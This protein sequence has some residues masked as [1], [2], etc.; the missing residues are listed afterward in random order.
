MD[1]NKLTE[2]LREKIVAGDKAG[3]NHTAIQLIQLYIDR[4]NQSISP[5]ANY[6]TV[7]AYFAL[8]KHTEVLEKLLDD[9]DKELLMQLESSLKAKTTVMTICPEGK[10]E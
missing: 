4:I 3:A 1:I 8:K 2:Q 5:L 7:F 9:A 10:E 6:T